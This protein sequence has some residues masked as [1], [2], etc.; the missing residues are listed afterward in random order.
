M[1][2]PKSARYGH[3]DDKRGNRISDQD[4]VAKEHRA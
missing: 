3:F 4:P 2:H 1:F